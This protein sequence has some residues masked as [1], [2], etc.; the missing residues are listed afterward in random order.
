[1]VPVCTSRPVC[2]VT[3]RGL[4]L[5][6]LQARGAPTT[7]ELGQ[8]CPDLEE[9]RLGQCGLC[10]H[11]K[12]VRLAIRSLPGE[13]GQSPAGEGVVK[14]GRDN[15]QNP[16]AQIAPCF[17]QLGPDQRGS[18]ECVRCVRRVVCGLEKQKSTVVLNQRAWA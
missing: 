7:A 8:P 15:A 4:T 16:E 5:R 14:P 2:G 17:Q 3:D 1:M 13:G 12:R 6:S 9:P 10:D 18:G 11:H